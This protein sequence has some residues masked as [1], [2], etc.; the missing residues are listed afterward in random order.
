[1]ISFTT[2]NILDSN[3][4]AIVN[5]VNCEGYMGKG[6]AYQFK[7]RYPA[8]NEEYVKQCKSGN[9]K[10]G[11]I[12]AYHET[13]KI[14][15][16]FPTKD[17]WRKKSKYEYIQKGLD[18]LINKLS[19]LNIKSI[20]FPPLG[21]GNGGLEWNK[22]KEILVEK[23]SPFEG[24]YDFIL[25]EPS[26]TVNSI[27]NKKKV[28]KLNASHLILMKLKIGLE[29]FNKTRLQK[30]AFLINI[31]SGE[32]YFKFKAYN[33]GPYNH[34]IDILSREIKEY[35]DYYNFNT[36]QAFELAQNTLMSDSVIEKLK[37]YSK[38]TRSAIE[39]LN[40]LSSDKK[41]E[42]ITTVLFILLDKKS[43][44]QELVSVEFKKWSEEKA[45]RFTDE[46]IIE[47]LDFLKKRGLII[48]SLMGL[49]LNDIIPNLH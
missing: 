10:I 22:V 46:E 29:K 44:P 48:N 11:S 43:I 26:F 33:Y 37:K 49:E 25:Y 5:T 20:A 34:S 16:N 40:E 17:K 27:K 38:P 39:F 6:I 15:L 18:T 2:G 13:N 35:Q 3:A 8:N 32:E 19:D 7:L 9:F 14:I 36:K 21:C 30:G 12:L 1:M 31:F 24:K 28:P 23:L 4:D 41:V 47:V 42:L 45:S